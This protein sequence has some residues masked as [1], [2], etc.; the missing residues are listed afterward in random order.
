ML[1]RHG[2]RRLHRLQP[3]RQTAAR[4][5]HRH[6]VRQPRSSGSRAEPGVAARTPRRAPALHQGRRQERRGRQRRSCG[7]P[8]RVPPCRPDR[9]DDIRCGPA[10][11][12]RG[13]PGRH[14]ERARGGPLLA[15]ATDRRLRLLEQG[16]RVDEGRGDRRDPDPVCV[17]GSSTG[18]ERAAPARLRVALRL[19]EGRFATST[20]SHTA[21]CTTFRRSSSGRAVS[22]DLVRWGSRTRAGWR[23]S[24]SPQRSGG[25]SRSSGAASRSATCSTWTTCSTRTSW[26]W[27]RSTARAG[28]RSTSAGERRPRSRLGRVRTAA[29]DCRRTISS[30]ALRRGTA[31]RPAGVLLRYGPSRAPLR[32]AAAHP[33]RGRRRA[34]RRLGFSTTGLRSSASSPFPPNEGPPGAHVL[35][36]APQRPD[37]LRRATGARAQ[38][39]RPR[40]DRPRVAARRRAAAAR[41]WRRRS[42]RPRSGRLPCRQGRGM[43]TYGAHAIRLLREHDVVGIHLPQFEAAGL[44][45][46]ARALRPPQRD[47]LPLRPAAAR[48]PAQP[49][50]GRAHGGRNTVAV[51]LGRPDRRLHAGLRRQHAAL[52]RPRTASVVPP[53]VVMPDPRRSGRRVVPHRARPRAERRPARWSGSRRFAAEKG[54]HVLLDGPV[55]Q[56]LARFPGLKVL[57]AGP[58]EDSSARGVSRRSRLRSPRWRA[59]VRSSARSTRSRDAGLP[60]RDR[61]P[62]W[63]RV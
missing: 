44:A 42:R 39:S 58:Y 29:G 62:R 55:P 15:G 40:G 7:G 32:M 26:P 18:C 56:P 49:R 47:H 53:P 35:P 22:T 34:A 6:P 50:R 12:L 59:L 17:S 16:V 63:F 13:E 54:I 61:L 23:G 60:R 4:W 36:A 31:R 1:P 10:R 20:S 51:A 33:C 57:F 45:L 9:G 19:L 2:W 38:C 41:G 27:A 30:A 24:S 5:T 14:P 28:G 52:R 37:D 11:R 8:G 48:R 21:G 3:C 25:R 46:C 43:P